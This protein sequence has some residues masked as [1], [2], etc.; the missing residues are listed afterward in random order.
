MGGG[1]VVAGQRFGG[2]GLST[3]CLVLKELH[4]LIIGEAGRGSG[5]GEWG[6]AAFWCVDSSNAP[7]SKLQ[8]VECK[9]WS[10]KKSR[11]PDSR[12]KPQS[13]EAPPP[14]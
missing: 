9:D 3:M 6:V 8:V 12:M 11:R 4:L 10:E 13:G 2:G 14:S 5:E 1:L 7:P